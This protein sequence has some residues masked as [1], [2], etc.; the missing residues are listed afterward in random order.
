MNLKKDL[1]SEQQKLL[2]QINFPILDKEYSKDEIKKCVNFIADY[3]MSLSIKNN[4]LK[5]EMQKYD[6]LM[7]ILIKNEK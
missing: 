1:T 5:S 2:I 7:R 3:Y 4:D 6:E